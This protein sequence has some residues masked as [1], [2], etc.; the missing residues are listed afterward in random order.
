MHGMLLDHRSRTDAYLKVVRA[1]VRPG[2]VVVD[3]GSGTGV[4]GVAAVRA[5]ASRVYA[6]EASPMARLVQRVATANGVANRM[7]VIRRWSQQVRLPERADVIVSELVGN[8][9][10]AEGILGTTVDAVRRFLKPGGRLIPSGIKLLATPMQLPRDGRRYPVVGPDRIRRWQDWYGID[11]SPLA[12]FAPAGSVVAFVNPWEARDWKPLGPT[13]VIRDVKLGER[14]TRREQPVP[15]PVDRAG[16]L[17]AVLLHFELRSG[18][19][20][21]L[22]TAYNEVD[23]D[24][25]WD[26]P[27]RYLGR[28]SVVGQNTTLAICYGAYSPGR[29][30]SCAVLE[31]NGGGGWRALH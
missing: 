3:L 19:R 28:P 10:F 16:R 5:G 25:H 1:V 9:P 13:T 29:A 23:K 31:R 2:D 18:G 4:F 30:V 27:V 20:A 17:D 24:N 12:E 7:T 11:F 22:S 21:F 14:P 26:S 8:E 15:L 6:I